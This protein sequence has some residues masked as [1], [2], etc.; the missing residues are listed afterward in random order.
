MVHTH[1]Q[2]QPG[3]Q[4]KKPLLFP[5]MAA[6]ILRKNSRF[7][8]SLR[9]FSNAA[10]TTDT[11]LPSTIL[12]AA[13]ISR[14]KSSIREESNPDRLVDLFKSAA[15]TPLFYG[16]RVIYKITIQK[17]ARARRPDLIEL[18]LEHQITNSSTPKS[19]GFLMRI[20][21]LYGGASMPDHAASTF[22][23][24]AVRRSERSL[25][26]LLSALL[27][28]GQHARVLETFKKAERVLGVAPGIASCNILLRSL[29]EDGNVV[30]ARN[31]LDEMP[32]SDLMPD[33]NSYNMVLNGYLKEKKEE[34][35][36]ELLQ[37][38]TKKKMDANVSTYNCRIAHLC[39]KGRTFEAEELLDV[40]VSKG[41]CPNVF[42]FN[43]LI[44]GFCNEGDACSAMRVFR[45]IH[46]M[47]NRDSSVASTNYTTYIVLLGCLV[48]KAEFDSALE[49]CNLC[50]S[51]KWVPPFQ[52]VKG[53]IHGLIK[54]SNVKEAKNVVEEMRRAVK[55]D[56]IEAWKNAEG[57]FAF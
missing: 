37:E 39:S 7:T 38:L 48:E 11:S 40:M 45:R 29:C 8:C 4:K 27:K 47:K 18:L 34:G 19:E 33:I 54:N 52:A 42:S 46:V 30:A 57:E 13:T 17:L 9:P 3:S 49:I 14:I 25:C 56:S 41:I 20:I 44:D 43:T 2:H 31:M 35:F 6:N 5:P 15:T 16:D 36:E 21:S 12:C 51:K 53:L 28:C 24:I 50:L 32:Q 23:R 10:A 1:F 55:G 26:A 22:D